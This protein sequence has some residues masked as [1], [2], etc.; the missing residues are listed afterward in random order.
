MQDGQVWPPVHDGDGGGSDGVMVLLVDM[1]HNGDHVGREFFSPAP[2]SLTG[3][4]WPRWFFNEEKNLILPTIKIS[5][6]N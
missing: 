1:I 5:R 2:I 3:N 6:Y 4:Y